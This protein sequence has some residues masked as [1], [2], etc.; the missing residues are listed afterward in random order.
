MDHFLMEISSM[1]WNMSWAMAF[2]LL[3]TF[4]YV[5]FW[6]RCWAVCIVSWATKLLC[7]ISLSLLMPFNFWNS[8]IALEFLKLCWCP[9]ISKIPY[10]TLIFFKFSCLPLN[11]GNSIACPRLILCPLFFLLSFFLCIFLFSKK[12]STFFNVVG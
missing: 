7:I 8:I 9:L 6:I 11:F 10:F 12:H 2:L 1:K 5:S 4:R 3:N